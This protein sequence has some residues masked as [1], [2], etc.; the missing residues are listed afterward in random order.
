[1]KPLNDETRKQH[2][3][4]WLYSEP[5]GVLRSYRVPALLRKSVE[6]IHLV[7]PA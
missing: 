5:N 7:N 2:I 4:D 3:F 1:M 6:G